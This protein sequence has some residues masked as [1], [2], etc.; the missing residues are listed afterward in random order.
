MIVIIKLKTDEHVMG[1]MSVVDNDIIHL[2]DALTMQQ[3]VYLDEPALMFTK[4]CTYTKS[5]DVLINRH[6]IMHIFRDPLDSVI[7]YYRKQLPVVKK[8]YAKSKK[9]IDSDLEDTEDE[10]MEAMIEKNLSKK[11]LH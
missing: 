10:I 6:D 9:K 3:V 5:F 7:K 8:F 11:E 2:S 4:Y 1:T